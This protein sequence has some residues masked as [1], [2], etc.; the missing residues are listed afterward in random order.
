LDIYVDDANMPEN[1]ELSERELE[2]LGLVATGASNKEIAQKLFISTNT[3][4]VHLRN[5]FSKIGVASR[6]E[7]A[8]YAV[9]ASLVPISSADALQLPVSQKREELEK[10]TE[11]TA[12]V[13]Q[14]NVNWR[15]IGSLAAIIIGLSGILIYLGWRLQILRAASLPASN[16]SSRIET[17]ASMPTPRSGLA[18][19][20]FENAIYAIAGESS[21]G[22]TGV[23]ER[24]DPTD[25]T[26]Q[27]LSPKELP[28]SDVKAALLGGK[29]YVPGGRLA[30]GAPTDALE[31]YDPGQNRWS[32]G[33]SLPQP[34]SG[35]S[36]VSYEGKLYL[37]GGWDGKKYLN[38]VFA[39]DPERSSWSA[40]TPMRVPRAFSGA[41][42]ANGKIYVMGGFDGKQAYN[43][44]EVYQPNLD[45]GS[46][47]PWSEAQ[48]LPERRFGMGIVSIAEVIYLIGGQVPEEKEYKSLLFVPQIEEWQP[49]DF[50]NT[51]H[52]IDLG[53]ASV[54]VKIYALGGQ[55]DQV[56]TGQNLS[57]QAMFLTVF[58]VMP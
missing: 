39:F 56:P 6:T 15:V 33:P 14:R 54:G 35:Y 7:A 41:A 47:K 51:D 42:V 10:E 37:F 32:R 40:K 13:R 44:N 21:S 31:I 17:L 9:N 38:K 22:V 2:I 18:V 49:V 24:F 45:N 50:L 23:V 36:I 27:M 26:W 57:Y 11:L 48:P 16:E 58:P 19:V 30:S 29:I 34:I 28:V 53:L 20:V 55:R 1:H 46:A 12:P 3:V 5:I 4:K 8:M 52:L 25:D 43:L